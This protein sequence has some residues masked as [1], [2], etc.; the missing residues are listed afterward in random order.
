MKVARTQSRLLCGTW[1]PVTPMP[2]EKRKGQPP[3]CE[4]TDAGY[5]GGVT[6]SSEPHLKTEWVKGNR[7][8]RVKG[9]RSPAE[10]TLDA[11]DRELRLSMAGCGALSHP[12]METLA[13]VR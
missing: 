10:R 12:A 2:R 11:R 9:G 4:S 5:R 7:R 8:L 3:E 1:E 6:C 13:A